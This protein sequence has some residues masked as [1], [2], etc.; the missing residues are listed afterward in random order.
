MAVANAQGVARAVRTVSVG[1]ARE[2]KLVLGG[3]LSEKGGEAGVGELQMSTDDIMIGDGDGGE[4]E[5]LGLSK[6]GL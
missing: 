5:G 2:K 3:K 4:L 1:A 6:D